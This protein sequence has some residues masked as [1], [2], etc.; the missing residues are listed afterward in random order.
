MIR[1]VPTEVYASGW[2]HQVAAGDLHTC[3]VRTDYGL[4]CWGNNAFGQIGDASTT[5]RTSPKAVSLVLPWLSVAAGTGT[6]CGIV[7]NGST[8]CWV[9]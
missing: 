9:S 6:T 3:A 2:W 7:M 1:K 4:W 8:F 5:D